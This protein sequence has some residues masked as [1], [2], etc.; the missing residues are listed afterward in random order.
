[1]IVNMNPLEYCRLWLARPLLV[2][3]YNAMQA[4]IQIAFSVGFAQGEQAGRARVF[5][6]FGDI[7][8]AR[9]DIEVRDA[10]LKKLKKQGIH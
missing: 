4:E 8:E 9:H 3:Q 10:D 1:M 5:Q 7:L 2:N 6:E